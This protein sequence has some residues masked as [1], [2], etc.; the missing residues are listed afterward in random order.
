MCLRVSAESPTLCHL[1]CSAPQNILVSEALLYL[2][3][4]WCHAENQAMFVFLS[5]S[6][7]LRRECKGQNNQSDQHESVKTAVIFLDHALLATRAYLSHTVVILDRTPPSLCLTLLSSQKYRPAAL[8]LVQAPLFAVP[9]IGLFTP[10][11]NWN[12]S[13][14]Q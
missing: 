9:S 7:D 2:S 4:F 10:D 3:A 11:M 8:T 13:R 5:K 6:E 14:I 1:T 12:S